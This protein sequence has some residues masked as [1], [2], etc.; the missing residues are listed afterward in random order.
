MDQSVLEYTNYRSFLAD[1]CVRK[2]KVRPGWSMRGWSR[3]LGLRSHTTLSMILKGQ[4]NPRPELAKRI[5]QSIGL[6]PKEERY[7]LD[8]VRLEKLGND[9]EEAVSVMDRLAQTRKTGDFKYLS[10]DAFSML[11]GWHFAIIREMVNLADFREDGDW[12]ARQLEFS[13]T[14]AQVKG[15]IQIL[16]QL[17]LL[18]RVRGRLC[19]AGGHIDMQSEVAD[20]GMKRFHEQMLECA[21]KSIRK[22]STTERENYGTSFTILRKD[23]SK[24]KELIRKF[25]R[26]L[27]GLLESQGGT[28]VYQLETAFFPAARWEDRKWN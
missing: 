25:H 8:L 16:I 21:A 2:K 17:G 27:S 22:H 28:D 15:A 6:G 3:K 26:D 9:P 14:P 10:H 1:Y 7:F 24:A 11:S 23:V 20:E 19:T 18:T 12:I 4:R 13:V 5:T